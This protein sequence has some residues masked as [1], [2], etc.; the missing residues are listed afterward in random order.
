MAMTTFELTETGNTV[1]QKL[2]EI[3]L[4]NLD[5]GDDEEQILLQYVCLQA[6]NLRHLVDAWARRNGDLGADFETVAR[7]I[8]GMIAQRGEELMAGRWL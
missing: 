4:C 8:G 5:C 6:N 1:Y 2:K 3:T 7:A